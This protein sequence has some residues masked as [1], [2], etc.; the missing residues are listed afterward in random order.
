MVS[1][2]AGT[3]EVEPEGGTPGGARDRWQVD[4]RWLLGAALV[5]LPVVILAIGAWNYRWM[6]DDGFINLRIV[7]QILAGHGPVFN[8]GE[9]VEASTSPLWVG[10]LTVGDLLTPF[11]IEWVAVLGGMALTLGG[12]VLALAG[13]IR[14][15]R[16]ISSHAWWLPVG[17][18]VFAALPPV[19][20]FSTSGLENG[21]TFAWLGGC[22]FI[23]AT[24][25]RADDGLALWQ[26][27]VLGLG[28]LVRPE[29]LLLSII[30]LGVVIGAQWTH[31]SWKRNVALLVAAFALPVAYEVFRMGYYGSLV[32]NSA[33]AKE[34]SR[35]YWSFGLTY[36]RQTVVD[37]Y[38]LWV[39]LVILLVGAYIP[40]ASYLRR[41]RR[42]RTLLVV[43]A[44][45][46]GGLLLAVY[47]VRV[48]GDFMHARLLLPAL[49]TLLAPVGVVPA[50]KKFAVAAL[51][52]PWAVVV[53][54]AVRFPGEKDPVL[55]ARNPNAITAS[56]IVG[57]GFDAKYA[58]PGVY[59]LE[60]RLPGTPLGRDRAMAFYGVGATSYALGPDAYVL[61]LLGLGD[62]FT[63]HLRL[64]HRAI[65]AHEKPL[66]TPW[67]AARLLEPGSAVEESDFPP[68]IFLIRPIDRPDGQPFADRVADARKALDCP[69]LRDFFAT[70]TAPLDAGRF[71]SN[72]GDAFTNFS[73]RIPPEPRDALRELCPNR[74]RST[75]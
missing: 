68:P 65:V 19:W 4:G 10:L 56:Q 60:N 20:R 43:G 72:L 34:A 25:S 11:R 27:F 49:F 33:I 31:E 52:V 74:A 58:E 46:V 9:R 48:G 61:D 41:E 45:F 73:F 5:A 1:L 44:F 50:T 47:I 18:L 29:L 71:V 40:L 51:V 16:G 37:S 36:L 24:W 62:P 22:L 42:D 39:P 55:G 26:A 28:P 32:P 57:P 6:A 67:I 35:S 75:G 14:L 54:V 7:K 66:P 3:T 64:Q 59:V 23:L 69:R 70:Y 17:A 30:F 15:Q 38:A 12:L 8:A 63:S 21:L 2:H 53:I 13:S